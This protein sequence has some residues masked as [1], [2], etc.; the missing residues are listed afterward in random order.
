MATTTTVSTASFLFLLLLGSSSTSITAFF[1]PPSSSQYSPS[2]YLLRRSRTTSTI[3]QAFRNDSSSFGPSSL[4]PS[5]SPTGKGEITLVGAGPGDPDLLTLA[6]IRALSTADIVVADRLIPPEML[7]LV[8]GTLKIAGKRPGCAEEAQQEIYRWVEE[9]V[10]E[11]KHV[12]RLKIGDPFLFGRGGEEVLKYRDALG[13]EPRLIPGVSSA[14]A[15]PLLGSIP[16]THRGVANQVYICTGFG[17]EGD[18]PYLAPYNPNQTA[19]F[20]MA[21]GRL[22]ELSE[23]LV[24]TA[25]YPPFTPVAIVEQASTPRQRTVVGRVGTIAMYAEKVGVKAPA[26]IVVGE[27][28]R[29]LLEEEGG[30]EEVEREGGRIVKRRGEGERGRGEAMEAYMRGEM[31]EAE[32]GLFEGAREGGRGGGIPAFLKK[33]KELRHGVR[34]EEGESMTARRGGSDGAVRSGLRA[35]VV[36]AVRRVLSSTSFSSM[37]K[38]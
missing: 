14:L 17:K 33:R 15:A 9:G 34:N 28:V 3:L 19:V 2:S 22:V 1:L 11:E 27:V 21:V 29:V 35:A 25:G 32:A 18:R 5:F 8:T 23:Q 24:Q 38:W 12:V 10:K 16:V 37:E 6:A 26:V 36:T 7:A 20:L 13:V 31:T 4:S 30:E